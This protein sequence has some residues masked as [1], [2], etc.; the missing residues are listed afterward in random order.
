MLPVAVLGPAAPR[1]TSALVEVAALANTFW[2]AVGLVEMAVR[3]AVVS[4]VREPS[5]LVLMPRDAAE[6]YVAPVDRP[7]GSPVRADWIRVMSDW[8]P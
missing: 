2:A 7:W 5:L 3:K 8:A 4:R 1:D 6:L